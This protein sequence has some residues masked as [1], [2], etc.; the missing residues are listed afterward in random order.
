MSREIG[1]AVLLPVHDGVAPAE[2]RACLRSVSDQTLQPRQVVLVIDGPVRQQLRAVVDEFHRSNATATVVESAFNGG[3]GHANGLGLRAV[4]EE[5]VAKV[6]A[7]DVLLPSRLAVQADFVTQRRLDVC[8]SAMWEF[9][10]EPSN[11]TSLRWLPPEHDGIVKR[12]RTNNPINHPTM[13]FRRDIAL[14]AGGYTSVRYMEDYDLVARMVAQGA[15]CGNL[16]EPLVLFRA[17]EAHLARRS[18][19]WE[20]MRCEVSLQRTLVRS[21]AV[22]V[23]RAVANLVWRSAARSLPRPLLRRIYSRVLAQPVSPDQ[24]SARPQYDAFRDMREL[25]SPLAV[26]LANQV[27]MTVQPWIDKAEEEL[28]VADVGSG[29]GATAAALAQRVRSVVAYEPSAALHQE[30]IASGQLQ[31]PPLPRYV[32]A[33]VQDIPSRQAFDVVV[34]DN[35]Y[36]HLPDHRQALLRLFGCLK[37]GGVVFLLVPNKL[38][39]WEAHYGLPFLSWLPLPLASRYL[40]ASGRGRDY[41][42]ASYAPTYWSLARELRHAGFEVNFTLPGDPHATLSGAPWHYRLGM[43]LLGRAPWLWCISKALLVVAVRPQSRPSENADSRSC[44]E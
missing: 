41:T 42:D 28:D 36:E 18:N 14:A 34:L 17:G 9:H 44:R 22:R 29:Y 5:W 7:D 35:V 23:P 8:G 24:G 2:L 20:V 21:G 37:D 11:V 30:A 38:W 12:L 4:T 40:R 3:A 26:E 15:R 39:P 33:G 32:N 31:T 13:F 43:R 27:L 10:G 25:R 19:S 6:D 1:I 16:S